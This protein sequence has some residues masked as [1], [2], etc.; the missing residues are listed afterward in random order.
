MS[1]PEPVEEWVD[2]GAGPVVRPYAM[3]RGR[4]RPVRGTFDR[5]ALV[6]A[7]VATTTP[8]VGM[9]PEHLSIIRLCQRPQIVAELTA[10]LK[11]PLGTIRVMLGDLLNRGLVQ[12][13]EPH[14]AGT[15]PDVDILEAAINGLRRL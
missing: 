10:H 3:T 12:V 5:I 1:A 9:E 13:H 8:E 4:T 7:T 6:T 11:L 2:D 14:P 15:R